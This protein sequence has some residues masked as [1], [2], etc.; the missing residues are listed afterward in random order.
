MPILAI[1][2][3]VCLVVGFLY[4]KTPALIGTVQKTEWQRTIVIEAQ[5][6]VSGQDW[7]DQLPAGAKILACQPK[8]RSRQDKPVA[9]ATEVCA[10]QPNS[11]ANGTA[12]LD[13]ACYYEVYADYC[14]YQALVW[15]TVDR[16]QAQ[17]SDL[18][19]YWPKAN[20]TNNQRIGARSETYTAYFQTN[21][22]VKQYTT[23]EAGLFAQFLPN[24][25]W[26]L[27]LDKQGAVLD[28]SLPE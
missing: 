23:G 7:R 12:T 6:E 13:K 16:V 26:L 3:M 18:Q 8:D 22:G 9:G 28:V 4:F 11:Q 20:P 1:L 17:G 25:E 14:S 2:M 24:S 5:N 10:A 15:Q 19:P 27:S 21:D